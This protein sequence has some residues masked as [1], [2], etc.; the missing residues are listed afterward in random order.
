MTSKFLLA[1]LTLSL[2]ICSV[3]N[4]NLKSK[5]KVSLKEELFKGFIFTIDN[6]VNSMKINGQS[7]LIEQFPKARNWQMIDELKYDFREGDVIEI[8]GENHLAYSSGNPAGLIGEIYYTDKNGN[9][10]V[11]PTND[12]W[13]CNG[14]PAKDLGAYGSGAWGTR[15]EY[16][17]NSGHW[18]WSENLADGTAVC[19]VTLI[20]PDLVSNSDDC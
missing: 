17:L 20:T 4:V 10:N 13:I 6:Y 2:I 7:I 5:S 15:L 16:S 3:L 9:V 8:T 12:K 19:S 18:I 1:L 14:K 11:F